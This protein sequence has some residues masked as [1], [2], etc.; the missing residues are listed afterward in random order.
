MRAT[1]IKTLMRRKTAGVIV[2]KIFEY[3]AYDHRCLFNRVIQAVQHY[4]PERR[5]TRFHQSNTVH[6]FAQIAFLSGVKLGKIPLPGRMTMQ[7][8]CDRIQWI[9]TRRSYRDYNM[10]GYLVSHS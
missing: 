10:V 4:A 8:C 7:I 6:W 5:Q 9:H 2:D 1:E 3:L